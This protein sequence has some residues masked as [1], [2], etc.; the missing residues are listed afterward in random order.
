MISEKDEYKRMVGHRL[1]ENMKSFKLLFDM[2]HYGNCISI[3]C[4]ELDQIIRLLFLLN[5]TANHK[6]QFIYSSINN[7]KWYTT[8]LDHK[9]VYVTDDTLLQFSE[10]LTGWDK[11]IYEFGFS[12]KNLSNNFNYGSRDPIKSMNE[13][14]R[15][16]LH[17]YVKEYHVKDFPVEYSLEDLIPVLPMIIRLISNNLNNYMELI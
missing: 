8:G 2:K 10:S 7:Q 1:E 14:D 12:F 15:N 17:G 9:R 5:S 16:R 3:M 4:Q 6:K 13:T 11:C